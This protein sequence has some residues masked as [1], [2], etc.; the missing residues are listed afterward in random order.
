MERYH[1]TLCRWAQTV[2]DWIWRWWSCLEK[3]P[4]WMVHISL[5]MW[6][7]YRRDHSAECPCRQDALPRK[8]PLSCH[9]LKYFGEQEWWKQ[10]LNPKCKKIIIGNARRDPLE[11]GN[12]D[13]TDDTSADKSSEEEEA[14]PRRSTRCKRPTPGCYLCDHQIT[15]ASR[16]AKRW[17]V[18]T[19]TRGVNSV[20]D[21]IRRKEEERGEKWRVNLFLLSYLADGVELYFLPL[22]FS[23]NFYLTASFCLAAVLPKSC[24]A[25]TYSCFNFFLLF[26]DG[27]FLY[28]FHLYFFI[29]YCH[30]KNR[31]LTPSVSPAGQK[32]F[33]YNVLK[34][35]SHSI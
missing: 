20:C 13:T 6:A 22:S 24:L 4:E 32:L 15:G 18:M 10:T 34:F 30:Q 14:L 23:V 12:P 17:N 21:N 33:L 7:H 9:G 25:L 28:L 29:V 11:V 35:L 16:S 26:K 2:A 5:Y 1:C 27:Q 31:D 8:R 3:D 19:K